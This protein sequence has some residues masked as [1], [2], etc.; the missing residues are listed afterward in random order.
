MG[1]TGGSSSSSG[2]SAAHSVGGAASSSFLRRSIMDDPGMLGFPAQPPPM[3]KAFKDFTH[4]SSAMRAYLIGGFF[5][6]YAEGV[7]YGVAPIN[8]GTGAS[9]AELHQFTA[10]KAHYTCNNITGMELLF[11]ALGEDASAGYRDLGT[12]KEAWEKLHND[13]KKGDSCK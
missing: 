8:P 1:S 13:R 6:P 12:L 11:Q 2:G 10:A 7:G 9:A 5:W 3:L 4:W